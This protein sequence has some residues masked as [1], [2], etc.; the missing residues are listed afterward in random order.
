M[1]TYEAF[2][3]NDIDSLFQTGNNKKGLIKIQEYIY[4]IDEYSVHEVFF[5]DVRDMKIYEVKMIDSEVMSGDPSQETDACFLGSG[6]IYCHQLKTSLKR[7]FNLPE[8][9]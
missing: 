4:D 8:E 7:F 6:E 5:L 2:S 1:K 9:Y 3:F